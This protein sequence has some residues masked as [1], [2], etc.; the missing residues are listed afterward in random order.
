M[1]LVQDSTQLMATP[2]G[3]RRLHAQ[4]H[5]QQEERSRV[6]AGLKKLLRL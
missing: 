1:A 3:R 6:F 5:T 4:R 2:E